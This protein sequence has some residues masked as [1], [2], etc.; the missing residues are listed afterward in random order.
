MRKQI[1]KLFAMFQQELQELLAEFP[2]QG[3][4]RSSPQCGHALVNPSISFSLCLYVKC[5]NL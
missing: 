5:F 1:F 3:G 4:Q 2:L